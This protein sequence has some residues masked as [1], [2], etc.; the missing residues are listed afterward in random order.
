MFVRNGHYERAATAIGHA[1]ALAGDF[2]EGI[3]DLAVLTSKLG[4]PDE[5]LALFDRALNGNPA[6]PFPWLN[7][8]VALEQ[9]GRFDDA[10]ASYR[11][12]TELKPDYVD[13]WCNLGNAACRSG[14]LEEGL[15]HFRKALSI[16]Q[17]DAD[18]LYG[19]SLAL[20]TQGRLAEGFALF[21]HRWKRNEADPVR[22][23]EIPNWVGQASLEGKRILLW[24]EQGYGDTLQFCRY[25]PLVA[26]LGANVTLEVQPAL[27]DLLG[28]LGCSVVATGDARGVFDYQTP[29]LSL[30]LAFK[31]DLE[32]IPSKTPYL[33]ASPER[34]EIW[35]TR[36]GPR[37]A[38]PR[39]GIA[40][41]GRQAHKND[42]QRSMPLAGFVPLQEK[43][44]LFLLQKDL[45]DEDGATLAGLP[46]VR[47]LGSQIRDFHDTAAIVEI[48]DLVITVD[49][50]LAHLGG[51][52]AKPTCVLLPFAPDWRW[53]LERTDSPWYP[54]MKL[55]RQQRAGDWADV[56]PRVAEFTSRARA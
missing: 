41:S 25:A 18:S 10:M 32:T 39:I 3:H 8:G 7:K 19:T 24:A 50:S 46:S 37:G 47:F 33:S 13:A 15:E 2:F 22:H 38:K 43:A 35:R 17:A 5:A 54:T 20:L 40:C 36:L 44:E 1:V 49:T 4:R 56:M 42:R 12:A 55:F 26:R 16:S 53:L 11:R 34:V 48:L 31:T 21:E 52:L 27:K 23:T 9:L 51:A 28:S 45:R 14:R 30:P 29:L 6:H